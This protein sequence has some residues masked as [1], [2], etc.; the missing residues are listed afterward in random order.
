MSIC[1]YIRNHIRRANNIFSISISY[2]KIIMKMDAFDII[3]EIS[4]NI[5]DTL[6]C[7]TQCKSNLRHSDYCFHLQRCTDVQDYLWSRTDTN[8]DR[9]RSSS[10]QVSIGFKPI[11]TRSL[12]ILQLVD[13]NCR[14]DFS[15][16]VSRSLILSEKSPKVTFCAL[17]FPKLDELRLPV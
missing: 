10:L 15:E 16:N 7:L 3:D 11:L 13:L 5:M 2:H 1:G 17:V 4:L 9:G 6:D 14:L 8:Y 12:D